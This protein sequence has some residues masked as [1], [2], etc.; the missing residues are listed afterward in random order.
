MQFRHFAS[1][2]IAKWGLACVTILEVL[3]I[4][5]AIRYT[6]CYFKIEQKMVFNTTLKPFIKEM[7]PNMELWVKDN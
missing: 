6:G 3:R 4:H 7:Q 2:N 5:F 1:E